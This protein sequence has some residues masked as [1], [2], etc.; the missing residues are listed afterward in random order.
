M[1]AFHYV[2]LYST[3]GRD[4]ARVIIRIKAA[5]RKHVSDIE[6]T[7]IVRP[8]V[9]ALLSMLAQM[10]AK[11]IQ[12][13]SAIEA[14]LAHAAMTSMVDVEAEKLSIIRDIV[15]PGPA[16]DIALRVYDAQETRTSGP[17]MVFFHG[18]GFVIGD[19][20]TYHSVC[21]YFAKQLDIPVIAV[22]Y[23]LAPEHP[24]PAAPDDCEAAARWVAANG[25]ALGLNIA[26]LVLCGDSAGGNLA[27]SVTQSLMAKP[28]AVPV[29]AQFPLYP[30]TDGTANSGSMQEFADGYLLTKDVMDWFMEQYKPVSGDL[31]SDVILGDHAVM[32]PTLVFT[33]GLDPL[34]DQGR[35]YAEALKSAGVRVI[36]GE[37]AGNIH[38]FMNIRKAIPSSVQDMEQIVAHMQ[39]LIK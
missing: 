1:R 24:F 22:D 4:A 27:I 29:I 20:Q 11:P 12:D 21:T 36:H 2:R 39:E 31:R 10:Q 9:A 37:A 35:A 30:V 8:D 26:G 14:R 17:V 13:G 5:G 15:C 19:L 16:G 25:A 23:R 3:S 7:P 28:A 32:P 33:A 6:N 34:R 18:G 38:G